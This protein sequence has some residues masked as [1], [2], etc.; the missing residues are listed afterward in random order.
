[1]HGSDIPPRVG[2][3]LPVPSGHICRGSTPHTLHDE[4]KLTSLRFARGQKRVAGD[5]LT[6]GVTPSSHMSR[7]TRHMSAPY[8]HPGGT[9][10]RLSHRVII[11][12]RPPGGQ[13][14]YV[15]SHRSLPPIL[16]PHAAIRDTHRVQQ[17][18]SS[19]K[20]SSSATRNRTGPSSCRWSLPP[21]PPPPPIHATSPS[22][23]LCTSGP[24]VRLPLPFPS[25][26]CLPSLPP[27]LPPSLPPSPTTATPVHP[28]CNLWESNISQVVQ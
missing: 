21:C 11:P 7:I 5:A 19:S 14:A 4:A 22:R 2:K 20:T 15:P 25:S 24:A 6:T 17:R 26:P 16:L 9:R 12:M 8:T 3:R 10:R 13:L 23:E 28:P 27:V 1:M 18:C